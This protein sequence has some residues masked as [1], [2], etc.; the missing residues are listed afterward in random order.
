MSVIRP[1]VF[2]QWCKLFPDERPAFQNYDC[3]FQTASIVQDCL[4]EHDDE[5]QHIE[6][7]AQSPDLNIIINLC[8]R[9]F[10]AQSV[11]SY[12]DTFGI[13]EL[14]SR[15]MAAYTTV[16]VELCPRLKIVVNFEIDPSIFS[17]TG[18]TL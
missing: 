4:N 18:Q 2:I 12:N 17:N 14:F 7:S 10:G 9:L 16:F 1:T 8:K 3:T 11:S 15:G 13:R 5:V 6:W